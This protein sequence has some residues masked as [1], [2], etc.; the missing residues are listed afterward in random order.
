MR[1]G[2]GDLGYEIGDSRFGICDWGL[3]IIAFQIFDPL[4]PIPNLQSPIP[5]L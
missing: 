5:Y 1:L 2:I 4:S 3:M